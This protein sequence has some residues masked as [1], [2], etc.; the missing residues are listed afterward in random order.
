MNEA[1]SPSNQPHPPHPSDSPT[2]RGL[3]ALPHSIPVAR[4]SAWP[5]QFWWLTLA[6]GLLSAF[7]FYGNYKNQGPVIEIEFDQ[8]HGLQTEDALRFRGIDIGVVEKIAL[9]ESR[10]GILV[11]VRLTPDARGVVSDGTLFWIVRPM[12]SLEAVRG[13][14]TIVGPKYIAMEPGKSDST[15][16]RRFQ[17]LNTPPPIQPKESS[18][19]IIL[20]AK[21][22][23]GLEGGAPIL[24]RGFR[25]GDVLS[26]GL[27]SDARS[28][29][30]RCAIDPEYHELVRGNSK[31]WVRSGWRFGLGLDGVK[32]E[33]DSLGQI[34]NGGVEFATPDSKGVVASTGTRF[35]LH[36]NPQDEWLEWQPSLPYGILWDRLQQK[37]PIAHRIVLRWQQSSFGFTVNK[38]KNGWALLLDDQTLLCPSDLMARPDGAIDGSLQLEVA[39]ILQPNP[40]SREAIPL[41]DGQSL[42]RVPLDSKPSL[43]G[44]PFSSRQPVA[45][46]PD[47]PT[48]VLIIGPDAQSSILIDKSRLVP[49]AAGWVI[50]SQIP[51]PLELAGA[52][53]MQLPNGNIVGIA[54][55]DKNRATIS[56][57]KD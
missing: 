11:S 4:R 16:T 57:R 1:D 18:V 28:V 5:S 6:C 32:L 33:A 2:P 56:I 7:L 34:L 51:V 15:R 35:V 52:P 25:I 27:A 10:P 54:R 48:D 14:E 9:L 49:D 23:F 29:I 53:V 21:K 44:Q 22:R 42:V 39:G 31:F 20:D 17:G 8:G 47:N 50:D 37:T 3:D 36:E 30:V 45:N 38:Q 40:Q 41:S 43:P 12:V 46:R 26:V 55:L 19:E 24:H 13:L